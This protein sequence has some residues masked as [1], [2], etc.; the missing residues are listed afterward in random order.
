[1][2]FSPRFRVGERG[3][4]AALGATLVIG[5][6]AVAYSVFCVSYQR[7]ALYEAEVKH[8]DQVIAEFIEL[9]N[10]VVGLENGR[11][12]SVDV[13]MA[14]A[15]ITSLIPLLPSPLWGPTSGLACNVLVENTENGRI[16]FTSNYRFYPNFSLVY[17][18]G[19][20]ILVQGE[21]NSM[22]SF[23]ALVSDKDNEFPK[24][25]V[26]LKEYHV[27][28]TPASRSGTTPV[29]LR[30]TNEIHRRYE[31]EFEWI[32]FTIYSKYRDAWWE[33][34]VAENRALAEKGYRPEVENLVGGGVKLKIEGKSDDTY[35][36]ICFREVNRLEVELGFGLV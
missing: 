30:V 18:Q 27:V 11:S 35:D 10:R 19:G 9:K 36:I 5:V 14:A 13:S 3:V 7:Y 28:K 17:E 20:V 15:P 29:S 6:V 2:G 31:G 33:Y 24:I 1:M 25:E 34:F 8:A 22:L 32:T 12:T 21:Y 16:V 4:S 26:Y 23:P